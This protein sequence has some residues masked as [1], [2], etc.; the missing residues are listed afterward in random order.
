MVSASSIGIHPSLWQA[1][2]TGCLSA[3]IHSRTEQTRGLVSGF[4]RLGLPLNG[5]SSQ[6]IAFPWYQLRP[7][8][9]SWVLDPWQILHLNYASLLTLPS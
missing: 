8:G 9:H 1:A 3:S 4:V 7:Y 2:K 6:T 5:L